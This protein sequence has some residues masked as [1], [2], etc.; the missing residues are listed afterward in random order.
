[1]KAPIIADAGPLIALARV[2]LLSLLKDLYGTVL[3]P[4]AVWAELRIEDGRLGAEGLAN[5]AAEGWL[6]RVEP[7]PAVYW[8]ELSELLDPGEAEAISLAEQRT[9]RFLLIDERRGREVAKR[10]GLRVTGTAGVLLAAK[11]NRLLESVTLAMDRLEGAGYRLSTALRA[12][13]AKLAGESQ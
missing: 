6:L 8:R 12:E 11:E 9:Y 5:A 10:R 3:V 4:P 13:V 7:L 1:M 2:G